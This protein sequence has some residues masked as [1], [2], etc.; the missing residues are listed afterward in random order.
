ML[1]DGYDIEI[2]LYWL[3]KSINDETSSEEVAVMYPMV[4]EIFSLV[5]MMAIL[6]RSLASAEFCDKAIS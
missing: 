4:A 1:R 5:D 2:W 6:S 3:K